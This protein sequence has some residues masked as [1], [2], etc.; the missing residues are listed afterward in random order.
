[1]TQVD[2]VEQLQIELSDNP[3][4]LNFI[5]LAE[6]YLERHLVTEAESLVKRSLKFHPSSVSGLAL[7]ARIMR[8][9]GSSDEALKYLDQATKLAPDN[10]KAWLEQAEIF[11]E[12]QQGKKALKSFK[13]VLLLNPLHPMARR[14]VA[15]LEVLSA[16][17][18]EDDLFSMQPLTKAELKDNSTPATITE[19]TKIPSSL[20]RVLAL[21][22]AL[23]V[24]LD[25]KKALD[26]LNDCTKKYGSHPEIDSRRLRLSTYDSP[27]YIQPK[28][29]KK[30][31]MA[32]QELIQQNKISTLQEL[33]RRIEVIKTQ[34][35]ST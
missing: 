34:R 15:R 9:Q 25:T 7:L 16:D 22:D 24:R 29:Q 2:E 27:D 11:A 32:R 5:R 21:V 20:E 6:K 14:A 4:S 28:S 17:E 12:L 31:S 1:M 33:L 13:Q 10:W 19:W 3:K 26:L 18:Y 23:T 30:S 35:L 8:A